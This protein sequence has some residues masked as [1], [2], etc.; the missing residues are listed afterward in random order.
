METI[1]SLMKKNC[2]ELKAINLPFGPKSLF[3]LVINSEEAAG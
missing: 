2:T 1:V 3:V